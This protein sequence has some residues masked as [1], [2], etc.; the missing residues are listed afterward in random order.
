M[1][2]R[3]G[4][5]WLPPALGTLLVLTGIAAAG[6]S[7]PDPSTAEG[8]TC[9]G[10]EATIVGSPDVERLRGTPG[11]DVIVSAGSRIVHAGAGDDVVCVTG[12]TE[13]VHAADGADSVT[14]DDG[15]HR[16]AT[17]LGPGVNQFRGGAGPDRVSGGMDIDD[18]ST[19]AGPD[20]YLS[21]GR[22]DQGLTNDDVV[23]LGRGR[24]VAVVGTANPAGSLDG[25]SG[26]NTLVPV[27]RR[28][29]GPVLFDNASQTATA[30]GEE[31]LHW[32]RF[33][34][35]ELGSNVGGGPLHFAGSPASEWVRFSRFLERGPRV[36][37]VATGAGN[38]RVT[39]AHALG[40][41]DAGTGRDTLK[42][43]EFTSERSSRLTERV[44]V[45]LRRGTLVVESR[46]RRLR[47]VDDVE[48][49]VVDGFA[50]AILSGNRVANVVL[51]HGVCWTRVQ[52][53]GG[54]DQLKARDQACSRTEAGQ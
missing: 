52:G 36:G 44:S 9:Q 31:L 28:F 33:T 11:A 12:S 7:A 30:D 18:I 34:H 13:F 6:G 5:R 54:D 50:G 53:R 23:D 29:T 25:G 21:W 2:S 51:V 15:A 20:E 32:S 35:F 45:D 39:L 24:D 22:L 27:A 8:G 47:P 1:G 40:S 4:T 14:T 37:T 43:V 41:V 17:F 26:I 10:Q 49:L 48:N 19:G 3:V 16:T 42:L 46:S 38:D